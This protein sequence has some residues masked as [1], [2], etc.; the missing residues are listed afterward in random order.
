MLD[1]YFSSVIVDK[2][3]TT[4]Q[5]DTVYRQSKRKK[6][7]GKDKECETHSS[8][9]CSMTSFCCLMTSYCSGWSGWEDWTL[10]DMVE[11]RELTLSLRDARW[12]GSFSSGPSP[13]DG[14]SRPGSHTAGSRYTLFR[15]RGAARHTHTHPLQHRCLPPCALLRKERA[16]SLGYC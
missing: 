9:P 13:S 2:I 7:K 3:N 16:R 8:M 14:R 5:T 15:L 1:E 10:D 4:S 6:D 11:S 12:S